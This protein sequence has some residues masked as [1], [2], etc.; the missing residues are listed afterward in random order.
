VD[1]IFNV[2]E[3]GNMRWDEPGAEDADDDGVAAWSPGMNV[4]R[5]NGRHAQGPAA[6]AGG[7]NDPLPVQAQPGGPLAVVPQVAE[8]PHAYVGAALRFM[9]NSPPSRAITRLQA[10]LRQQP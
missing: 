2:D 10:T 7:S 3:L 9:A 4:A 6:G 1:A 8:G 5:P